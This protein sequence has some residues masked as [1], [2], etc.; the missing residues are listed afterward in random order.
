MDKAGALVRSQTLESG[1]AVA[2]ERTKNP[3]KSHE[4]S[5][6]L[7][8]SQILGVLDHLE[9]C[10]MVVDLSRRFHPQA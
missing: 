5:A 2:F 8:V 3:G 6:G 10:L 7:S 9:D 4:E 1:F